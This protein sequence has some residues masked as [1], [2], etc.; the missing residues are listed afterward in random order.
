MVMADLDQRVISRVEVLTL[1]FVF[2]TP[3]DI[4]ARPKRIV[5]TG[6]SAEHKFEKLIEHG[7]GRSKNTDYSAVNLR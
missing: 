4:S 7:R 5:H 3:A 2:Q 1:C 6:G